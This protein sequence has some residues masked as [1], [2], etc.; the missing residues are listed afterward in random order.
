MPPLPPTRLAP[1]ISV[2]TASGETELRPHQN[3]FLALGNQCLAGNF[4]VDPWR[5]RRR[6]RHRQISP[7]RRRQR[8]DS[9]RAARR[10]RSTRYDRTGLPAVRGEPLAAKAPKAT[11]IWPGLATPQLRQGRDLAVTTDCRLALAAIPSRTNAGGVAD[12]IA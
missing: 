6:S 5:E 7:A 12:P 11:V 8:D 1:P 4:H 9:E 2:L 3:V 10:D